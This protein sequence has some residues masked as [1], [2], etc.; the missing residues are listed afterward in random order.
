MLHILFSHYFFPL[1]SQRSSCSLFFLLIKYTSYI[2][3]FTSTLNLAQFVFTVIVNVQVFTLILLSFPS[4]LPITSFFS[5][6]SLLSSFTAQAT[7]YSLYSSRLKFN[8]LL[9]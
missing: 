3:T 1:L 5:F 8:F 6:I 9:Y 7:P 2:L 4:C